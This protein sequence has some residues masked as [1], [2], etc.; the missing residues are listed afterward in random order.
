MF[1]LFVIRGIVLEL[2]VAA[3]LSEAFIIP[4]SGSANCMA[5]FSHLSLKLSN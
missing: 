4:G 3:M 1:V 5:K 2:A